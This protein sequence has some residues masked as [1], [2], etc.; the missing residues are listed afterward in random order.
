MGT[1]TEEK[2]AVAVTSFSVTFCPSHL[3]RF[4]FPVPCLAL[5]FFFFFFATA[6]HSVLAH[7]SS[8]CTAP[9]NV[10]VNMPRC[11]TRCPC[12]LVLTVPPLAPPTIPSI[13]A[14][15]FPS[16]S[17]CCPCDQVLPLCV[18]RDCSEVLL[19]HKG[20]CARSPCC[21]QELLSA[22]CHSRWQPWPTVSLLGSPVPKIWQECVAAVGTPFPAP[23][24]FLVNRK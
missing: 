18:L 12:P 3:P 9:H 22:P 16:P 24:Q 1:W 21:Q 14:S 5:L 2:V 19:V 23:L 15:S 20:W 6:P 17:S 8:P 13:S 4:H 10:L 11:V 7:M